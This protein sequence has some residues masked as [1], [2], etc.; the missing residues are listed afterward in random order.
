MIS[1]GQVLI[2]HLGRKSR[3][4]LEESHDSCELELCFSK[5]CSFKNNLDSPWISQ[6]MGGRLREQNF[7]VRYDH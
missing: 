2:P 5:D 3:M 4:L 6:H 7:E 1:V